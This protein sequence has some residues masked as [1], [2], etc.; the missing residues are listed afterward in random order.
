VKR[1]L[2]VSVLAI[3]AFAACS[4]PPVS[5]SGPQPAG[6]ATASPAFT[7]N[8]PSGNS[9]TPTPALR[10]DEASESSET[11]EGTAGITEKKNPNV[12]ESVVAAY[13]RWARHDGYD[14]VVFE[15]LGDQLPNYK[16]EYVDKP[17]RACGSGDVVPFAGDGWLSVRFMGAQAHAPEGDATIPVGDR[18]QS[19]NLLIVKDL[20]MICDFEGEV[21]WVLGVASPNKYRVLELKNPTRLVA[22]IKH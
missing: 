18:T 8:R 10:P 5:N 7:P 3:S 14:R 17:V 12:K 19:P 15:F 11:F 21:E 22:D 4:G 9:A 20:K 16:I 2:A 1:N 13:V 6:G